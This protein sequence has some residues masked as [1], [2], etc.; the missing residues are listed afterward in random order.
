MGLGVAGLLLSGYP[1]SLGVGGEQCIASMFA[2]Q[3]HKKNVVGD[4]GRVRPGY[5]AFNLGYFEEKWNVY[6][7]ASGFLRVLLYPLA[8]SSPIPV[9]GRCWCAHATGGGNLGTGGHPCR[10]GACCE[11]FCPG[12][13]YG[14]GEHHGCCQGCG[15]SGHPG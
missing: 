6:L 12:G 9:Q 3:S 8:F 14:A 1:G 5:A 2:G 10:G 7:S 15:G 13:R 4:D 11:G